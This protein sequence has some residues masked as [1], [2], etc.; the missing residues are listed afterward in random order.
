MTNRSQAFTEKGN[1]ILSQIKNNPQQHALP[2][3]HLTE[4]YFQG[5]ILQNPLSI[6]ARLPLAEVLTWLDCLTEALQLCNEIIE[7]KGFGQDALL[8]RILVKIQKS[9]L[10]LALADIDILLSIDPYNSLYHRLKAMRFFQLDR[11]PE[12]WQEAIYAFNFKFLKIRYPDL[13]RWQGE[14]IANKTLVLTMLDTRGGGD[15]IMFASVLPE[16]IKKTKHCFIETDQ[17]AFKLFQQSLPEATI[18]C[19]GEQP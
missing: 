1:A 2:Y 5:A 18:F 8:Q 3:L 7:I 9:D 4:Q 6:K 13:P 14:D 12:G 15:E 11:I 16:I 17:R 10:D 19:R